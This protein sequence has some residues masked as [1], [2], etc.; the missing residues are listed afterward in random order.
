MLR[1][2]GGQAAHAGSDLLETSEEGHNNDGRTHLTD[3]DEGGPEKSSTMNA[4]ASVRRPFPLRLA[5]SLREMAGTLARRDG[6]SLNHFISLAVAE[7]IRRIEYEEVT[8]N[9]RAR[10]SP[11]TSP[12]P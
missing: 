9:A 6:V 5:K 2:R 4:D 12:Y 1:V 3:L 11:H 7:K 8:E 10:Q